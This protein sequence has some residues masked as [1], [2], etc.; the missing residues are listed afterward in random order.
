MLYSGE[1]MHI[2]QISELSGYSQRMIRYLEDQGLIDPE[3]SDSNLRRFADKDLTRILKIKR[4]KEMGFAYAEI[5]DLID[6]DESILAEK[7]T[8]VL[9]RHHQ[10]A[11][12]LMEKIR[13]LEVLCFG[14]IKTKMFPNK[15]TT[16]AHPM[17]TA[18]RIRKLETIWRDIVA[19]YPD[20]KIDVGLWKFGELQNAEDLNAY[21]EVEAYETFKASSIMVVLE[22]KSLLAPFLGAFESNF[23]HLDAQPIGKF[24]VSDLNEFFGRSEIIINYVIKDK[25]DQKILHALIP[26]QA[27]FI[28]SGEATIHVES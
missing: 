19:L 2:G 22:K 13:Q 17:R 25:N 9:K 1:Y 11:Q 27:I 16:Y 10:D 7:G 28:A 26:Y 5:K 14:Q 18:Y 4:L 24:A 3:R 23:L 20:Y 8:E 6:K 12:D 21:Q 15:I